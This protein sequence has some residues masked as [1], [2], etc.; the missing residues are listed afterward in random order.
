[1]ALMNPNRTT[2]GAPL[3]MLAL[4]PISRMAWL[5]SG[6]TTL[7][8]T[9][10][11]QTSALGQDTPKLEP[12]QVPIEIAVKQPIPTSTASNFASIIP[13]ETRGEKL[14]KSIA[15][16]AKRSLAQSG[17]EVAKEAILE[18]QKGDY[19]GGG[20]GLLSMPLGRPSSR[21]DHCFR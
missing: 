9:V 10:F 21:T 4:R 13:L 1:M 20:M 18:C 12:A 14:T 16:A 2:S 11:V 15:M 7:S 5:A 6:M 8:L 17:V 3:A 19:P